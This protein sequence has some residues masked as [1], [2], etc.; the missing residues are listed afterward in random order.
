VASDPGTRRPYNPLYGVKK[1][2]SGLSESTRSSPAMNLES[3]A[4]SLDAFG[5]VSVRP[6]SEAPPRRPHDARKRPYS[7]QS[8]S[9]RP[10]LTA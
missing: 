1:S 6:E 7:R 5:D 3:S 10:A 8:G 4:H 2:R 9:Y